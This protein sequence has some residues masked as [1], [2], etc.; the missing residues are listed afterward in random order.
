MNN[1]PHIAIGESLFLSGKLSHYVWGWATTSSFV[2]YSEIIKE[3]I[4]IAIALF[5]R[6]DITII[7][8]SHIS[9]TDGKTS[10]YLE[11][12]VTVKNALIFHMVRPMINLPHYWGKLSHFTHIFKG[13]LKW[14]YLEWGDEQCTGKRQVSIL[15]KLSKS[16]SSTSLI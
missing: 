4:L 13:H 12:S 16:W 1:N 14:H 2:L 10:N 6:G 11:E 7:L 15:Y 5:H 9:N 3:F 8:A